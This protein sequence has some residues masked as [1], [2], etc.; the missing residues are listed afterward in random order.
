MSPF[1]YEPNFTHATQDVDHGCREAGSGVGAIGKHYTPRER[2]QGSMSRLEEYDSLSSTFDSFG[3]EES[4]NGPYPYRQNLTMR[5]PTY[6]YG[7]QSSENLWT[8]FDGQSS[9]DY[10]CG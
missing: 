9:N 4:N 5:Y 6:P 1:T 7:M 2:G 3:L 8:Q 10:G